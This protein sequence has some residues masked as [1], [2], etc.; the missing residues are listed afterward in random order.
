[1]ADNKIKVFIGSS[2][3][4]EA[5]RVVGLLTQA[6]ESLTTNTNVKKYR[7]SP[8]MDGF[9]VT[10]SIEGSFQSLL[11]SNEFFV[12][13]MTPD[14]ESKRFQTDITKK[15]CNENVLFEAGAAYGRY[16]LK[17]V[18]LVTDPT[19]EIVSELSGIITIPL[20]I[21]VE[22]LKAHISAV[23]RE[24][25]AHIGNVAVAEYDTRLRWLSLMKCKPALQQDIVRWMKNFEKQAIANW[26]VQYE[27]HGVLW[28]PPDDFLLF[29]VP[30]IEKFIGFITALRT[31]LGD[32]LIQVDS[33]L[34]FPNKYWQQATPAP[35]RMKCY[36][37]VLL[38][39]APQCVELAYDALVD[40]AK[41]ESK[42][43]ITEVDIVT[44]GVTTGEADLFFITAAER[45][46]LHRRFVEKHLHEDVLQ[47][48]WLTENTTS[49]T[50][51]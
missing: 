27:R 19:V 17:R 50:I 46:D 12:L 39:C 20:D 30:N 41:D 15:V 8:W 31:R 2:S 11:S 6:L 22:N 21:T 36:Q 14:A 33:R 5:R 23:A 45:E 7:V 43:G 28:G 47:D 42:R 29:S 48:G 32:N 40:A 24:I 49:M 3:S 9:G 26:D 38:S 10:N 51:T 34:V 18:L 35:G 25:D 44:V 16:G 13:L 4:N 1:M 37:M